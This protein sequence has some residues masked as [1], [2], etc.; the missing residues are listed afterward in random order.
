MEIR[1]M[2]FFKVTC[3][4][5]PF[6]Y[7][8]L[9]GAH[10]GNIIRRESVRTSHL[11]WDTNLIFDENFA[12]FLLSF[13]WQI[14]EVDV[15]ALMV[16]KYKVF[17][18][19][20]LR[21]K[22]PWKSHRTVQPLAGNGMSKVHTSIHWVIALSHQQLKVKVDKEAFIKKNRSQ[23]RRP[24]D[25]WWCE[26]PEPKQFCRGGLLYQRLHPRSPSRSLK[27]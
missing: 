3:C 16:V 20:F 22:K 23:G 25:Y 24:I 1:L 17:F 11:S 10:A 21:S 19:M 7:G 6:C 26:W 5:L 27:E 13:W 4:P 8:H 15:D 2:V 12:S 14:P 18:F 9:I